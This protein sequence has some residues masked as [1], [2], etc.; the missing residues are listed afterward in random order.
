[1]PFSE[2]VPSIPRLSRQ[3]ILYRGIG[4][5]S[6]VPD[7][8][9]GYS[10]GGNG[11]VSRPP[12]PAKPP[13]GTSVGGKRRSSTWK[14]KGAGS[15]LDAGWVAGESAAYFTNRGCKV[16]GTAYLEEPIQRAMRLSP[17]ELEDLTN[18]PRALPCLIN[19]EVSG[20]GSFRPDGAT[21]GQCGDRGLQPPG[22]L[23]AAGPDPL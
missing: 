2:A 17:A 21:R 13:V 4:R 10:V 8:L 16:T 11:L 3:G 15:I 12:T 14:T 7:A 18:L 22:S 23:P 6:T 20:I 9:P 1:M 5:A 19:Q